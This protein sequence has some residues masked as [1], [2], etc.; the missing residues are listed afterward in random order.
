MSTTAIQKSEQSSTPN[1]LATMLESRK[2]LLAQVAPKHLTPDRLIKLALLA[3]GR[4]DLL[5]KCSPESV[6]LA[7]IKSAEAGLEIGTIK[8]HGH[9]VPFKNR[10]T[11]KFEAT[12]IPGYQGLV[13]LAR[14]TGEI[15]DIQVKAVHAKD[16]WEYEEGLE[17]KLKHVPSEDI[18]PGELKYVYCIA[19][20]KDGGF[21][22]EVMSKAQVDRVRAASPGKNSPAWNQHYDEMAKKT[23]IRRAAKLWP[24]SSE[25]FDAAMEAD[26]K[27]EELGLSAFDNLP[28]E[29]PQ[30]PPAVEGEVVSPGD[31]RKAK[32]ALDAI[33]A[34]VEHKDRKALDAAAVLIKELHGEEHTVVLTVFRKAQEAF[35]ANANGK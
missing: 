2:K 35:D 10:E 26:Y 20:F 12:F 28:T 4:N 25:R 31:S 3:Q 13:A 29:P 27:S 8:G 9:M 33:K 1:T 18:D 5:K 7:V 22:V 34:A 23:V 14:Q 24:V 17:R 21:Q 15:S 32:E 30:A 6:V 11:G 16:T 19:R